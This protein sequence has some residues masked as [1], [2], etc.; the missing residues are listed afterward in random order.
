M[1]DPGNHHENR[2][3]NHLMA[4][5]KLLG[6]PISWCAHCEKNTYTSK[7]SAKT[8]MSRMRGRVQRNNAYRCPAR[9][10]LTDVWHFGKLPDLVVSGEIG[11]AQIIPHH[12]LAHV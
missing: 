5:D 12:Q 7:K 8:A 11:R 1:S 9:P 3:H 2:S 10:D 6:V 4:N